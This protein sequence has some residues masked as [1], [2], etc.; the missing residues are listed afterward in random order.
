M[1][2]SIETIR[3]SRKKPLRAAPVCA[4]MKAAGRNQMLISD[5]AAKE[6]LNSPLNLFN[7]LAELSQSTPRH[8]QRQNNQNGLSLFVPP[9]AVQPSPDEVPSLDGLL[10]NAETKIKLGLAHDKAVDLIHSAVSALH[11]KI[12]DI[13]AD[14]LPSV[15]TSASKMIEGIRRERLEANKAKAGRDVHL[16]FYTPVQRQMETYQVIDVV[17]SEP[18]SG[19]SASQAASLAALQGESK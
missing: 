11:D 17:D 8:N 5:Q 14:K 12:D 16:H 6:K 9:S 3:N 4:I 18:A 7:R 19:A 2:F 13:K 15:I 1:N 10:D